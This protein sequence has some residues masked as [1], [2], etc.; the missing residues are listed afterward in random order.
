VIAYFLDLTAEKYPT[1]F[2]GSCD[3][4]DD[5]PPNPCAGQYWVRPDMTRSVWTGSEWRDAGRAT[6][7]GDTLPQARAF[8]RSMIGEE[9]KE[10]QPCP[11]Y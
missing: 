2:I 10:D 8:I 3:V 6:K 5:P 9:E 7:I 4:S 1:P 11:S